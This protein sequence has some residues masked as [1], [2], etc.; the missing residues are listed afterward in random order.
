MIDFA[1]KNSKPCSVVPGIVHVKGPSR[2][3]FEGPWGLQI[4]QKDLENFDEVGH[5]DGQAL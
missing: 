3:P 5:T 2:C 4:P 1:S